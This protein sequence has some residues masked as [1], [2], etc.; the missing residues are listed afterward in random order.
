MQL[1]KFCIAILYNEKHL[2]GFIPPSFPL[3]ASS[4][5]VSMTCP[6]VLAMSVISSNWRRSEE[7]NL[8]VKL[9]GYKVEDQSH[10]Y[11][12]N[13]DDGEMSFKCYLKERVF[14]HNSEKVLHHFHSAI[15]PSLPK[16][17]LLSC[18]PSSTICPVHHLILILLCVH[19]ATTF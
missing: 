19:E 10:G 2:F 5:L 8:T 4:G 15:S 14:Q 13:K 16:L 11:F 6:P 1:L 3:K 17:L 18:I 12:I 7:L 9:P